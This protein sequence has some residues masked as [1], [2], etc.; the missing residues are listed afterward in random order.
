M[1]KTSV[2]AAEP[3]L[4]DIFASELK[5]EIK[6][7]EGA[8]EEANR[9]TQQIIDKHYTNE[10]DEDKGWYLQEMARYMYPVSVA[11]SNDLQIKAH[12]K[13]RYLLR[14]KTGL[15]FEKLVIGQKRVSAIKTW[16]RTFENNQAMILAG[17][18]IASDLAFGVSSNDFEEA[19][20]KLGVAL[21]FASQR[22]D[23]EW[24][25]GPDNLWALKEGEYILFEVKNEVTLERKEIF[26]EETGQI[27]NACAWFKKKYPGAKFKSI[28]IHP[29]RTVAK[30]AGFSE[31]VQIMQ[32]K[33]L[34]ELT[35][36]FHHFL[37][38]MKQAD[39]KDVSD[40]T[41]QSFLKKHYLDTEELTTRYS[42]DP[43]PPS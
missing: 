34:K 26:K 25:E 12:K 40:E 13:N 30:A 41:L 17:D 2:I 10:D 22:P 35:S 36:R 15:N 4:L 6:Y 3:K 14:P 31:P 24:K 28:L 43:L 32:K 27:N 18:E 16:L 7:R 38:E 21:G 11:T 20:R 19:L 23:K 39:L 42:V 8:F 5:A 29:S 1:E 9:I 37:L 33:Q